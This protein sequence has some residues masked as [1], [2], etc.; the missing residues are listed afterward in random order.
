M[1]VYLAVTASDLARIED[2]G[3]RALPRPAC[4]LKLV[5]SMWLEPDDEEPQRLMEVSDAVALVRF[6]VKVRPFLELV[7]KKQE[8]FH[9]LPPD[10][11]QDLNR[12]IIDDIEIVMRRDAAAH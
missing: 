9:E 3:Y 8:R 1:L 12:L 10:R 7:S 5:S 4:G 2:A 6:R 11:V